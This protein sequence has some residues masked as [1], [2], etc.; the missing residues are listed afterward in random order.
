[1]PRMPF[2]TMRSSD[3]SEAGQRFVAMAAIVATDP[4]RTL[5]CTDAAIRRDDEGASMAE[6]DNTEFDNTFT[7][8]SCWPWL[9]ARSPIRHDPIAA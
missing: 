4:E 3:V 2:V 1:M 8:A 9:A 7:H 5:R 6:S